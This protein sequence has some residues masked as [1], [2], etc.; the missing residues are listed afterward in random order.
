MF[1]PFLGRINHTQSNALR[2]HSDASQTTYGHQGV[3]NTLNVG[4]CY[5]PLI[6]SIFRPIYDANYLCL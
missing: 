3:V 1:R 2:F 5:T 4:C 6:E